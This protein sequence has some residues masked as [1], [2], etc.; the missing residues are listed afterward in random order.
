MQSLPGDQVNKEETKN[1]F[2]PG[3]GQIWKKIKNWAPQNDVTFFSGQTSISERR[4]CGKP[5]YSM[6]HLKLV[7]TVNRGSWLGQ[8]RGKWKR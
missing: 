4:T 1:P 6:G 7:E 2:G 5:F 8:R 3:S